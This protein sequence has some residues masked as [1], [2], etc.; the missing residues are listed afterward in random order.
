MSKET[1]SKDI[2][3]ENLPVARIQGGDGKWYLCKPFCSDC[4]R[5]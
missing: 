5:W 3:L 1:V 4:K 2:D